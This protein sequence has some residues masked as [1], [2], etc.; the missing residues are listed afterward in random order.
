MA[1]NASQLEWQAVK[2]LIAVWTL[3]LVLHVDYGR[4][5]LPVSH[6]GIVPAFEVDVIKVDPGRLVAAGRYIE[7]R[8]SERSRKTTEATLARANFRIKKWPRRFIASCDSKPSTDFAS[9]HVMMAA[10]SMSTLSVEEFSEEDFGCSTHAVQSSNV[11][12]NEL[13]PA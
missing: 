4:L 6:P 2:A 13:H 9:G 3:D 12:L 7:R 8:E 10:F 11:D 1:K 5:A